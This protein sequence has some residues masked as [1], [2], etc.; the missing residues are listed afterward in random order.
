MKCRSCGRELGPPPAV[1]RPCGK[2]YVPRNPD[3]HAAADLHS[4]PT[5]PAPIVKRPVPE[6]HE[7][8]TQ[9]APVRRR[10]SSERGPDARSRKSFLI[11]GGVLAVMLGGGIFAW[12]ILNAPPG[13]LVEEDVH[14]IRPKGQ[15]FRVYDDPGDY[16]FRLEVSALDGPLQAFMSGVSD[17]KNP[18]KVHE[19][20]LPEGSRTG[21]RVEKG[22]TET[23]EG[24]I[25]NRIPMWMVVNLNGDRTS[26][27]RV[28][29][30]LRVR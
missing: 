5:R 25:E 27:A 19:E 17:P 8:A 29:L 15:T 1:C 4:L 11:V 16:A 6:I 12:E 2:R 18:R 28:K 21:V 14:L 10:R 30:T 7:A 13:D 22:K 9:P 3:V 24:T 26:R 20:L 23:L